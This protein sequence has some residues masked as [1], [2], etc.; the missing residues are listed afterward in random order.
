MTMANMD[1]EE[2]FDASML[3]TCEEVVQDRISDDELI[4]IKGY[5]TS[6]ILSHVLLGYRYSSID[7]TCALNKQS[8]MFLE[9]CC[10]NHRNN[11]TQ[12]NI[13]QD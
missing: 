4:L 8:P 7:F 13:T 3:G 6:T 5:A 9:F 12:Y 1:G 11:I 10:S 2:S